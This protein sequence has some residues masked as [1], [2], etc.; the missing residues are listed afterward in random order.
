MLT[1]RFLKTFL[2]LISCSATNILAAPIEIA[3]LTIEDI[4]GDGKSGLFTF[5]PTS[6]I[7]TLGTQSIGQFSGDT[8]I[9]MLWQ[10][11]TQGEGVF[12]TGFVFAGGI[13][14]LPSTDMSATP[15]TNNGAVGIMDDV[16]GNILSVS[17][18]DFGTSNL[19]LAPDP[20]TL[21][22][23][24]LGNGKAKLRWSHAFSQENTTFDS[25][26]LF[27]DLVVSFQLEGTFHAAVVPVPPAIWLF[28][29]GLLAIFISGRRTSTL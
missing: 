29:S 26:F 23:F 8:G 11:A 25:Q 28:S 9:D 18:L 3:S 5:G 20:G 22:I 12:T 7:E 13:L 24:N 19:Y 17:S 2:I 4:D 10:G 6:E 16:T 27:A 14:I 15:G 1:K 21:Q